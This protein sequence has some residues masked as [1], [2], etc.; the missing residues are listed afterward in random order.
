MV[1]PQN[2]FFF[3][4]FM[5]VPRG[6]AAPVLLKWF[7]SRDVPTG[8][9]SP[10]GTLIPIPI[11]SLPFLVHLHSREFIRSMD[12]AKS[13]VLVGASRP[14]L[15]PDI[16]GRSSPGTGARNASFCFVLV[17]HLIL[18]GFVGDLSYSESFRGV[19]RLLLFRTLFLP[20]NHGRDR[21]ANKG[22]ER[23]R[24]RKRQTLR[25]NGNEQRRNDK[26]RCPGSSCPPPPPHL[27]RRGEGFG[28]VASPVPPS[29]GGACGGGVPPEAEIGY[30]LEARS[31]ALPT[32]RLLMAVGHDCYRKAPMNMNI[33]HGGVCIF[34]MGVILS[35]TKKIQFT[36]RLPLG[37]E[38]HMGKE[39]CCLRGSD[40]SHG[41]TFHSICGNSMI[42]KPSLTN[43]FMLEHDESL[44][45]IIDLLPI[46]FSASY[47]NGKLDHFLH[48]ERS[49]W[50]EN[51]EHN[52][53][54]LTMSPEKRYFFSIQ[55]T[56]SAT[57]VAIHTNLFTDPYAP[58]GTGSFGTGGWYTTIMEL[59][60]IFRIRIGF[61]LASPG[62]LRSLLR[63]LQKDKLHW[64]R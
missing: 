26:I 20:Y 42:Y 48:R 14:I 27:E 34:I 25:P 22:R 58:I 17:L 55:E 13:I 46:H 61:L 59:P 57:E 11:S 36:Q 21:L 41:P 8:A 39:R 18:L 64:N 52:N 10:S 23:A 62:G 24:R 1:Q 16:I 32:S 60:L 9:P 54:W 30:Y 63:Q 35:D 49:W 51:R 44:R 19:L 28:P 31:L 45:A 2:F 37:P 12:E 15:L 29:S 38:L 43:P 4:T 53:S 5:V 40:H 50:I 47:G 6:T 7:V 33:S 3:I 56:T